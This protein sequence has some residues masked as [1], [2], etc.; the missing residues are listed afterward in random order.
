MIP[1]TIEEW[2]F[3]SIN[4]LIRANIPES[5]IHDFKANIPDVETVTNLSCAFANTKGGFIILGVKERNG[6]FVI[7]GIEYNT[8]IAHEF[9]KKIKANPTINFELPKIIEI[10]KSKKN[11]SCN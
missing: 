1:R 7:E 4:E 8:E 3:D 2:N 5:D 10:P 11:N 6:K 9:G